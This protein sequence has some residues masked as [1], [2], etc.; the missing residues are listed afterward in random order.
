MESCLNAATLAPDLP[1]ASF[2]RI[3]GAAGFSAVEVRLGAVAE[4]ARTMGIDGV[5]DFF[6]AAGVIPAHCGLSAAPIRSEEDYQAALRLLPSECELAQALGIRT[7]TLV[8]PYRSDQGESDPERMVAKVREVARI[9]SDYGL[10]VTLEFLGL[11]PPPDRRTRGPTTL[12]QTLEFIER[13]DRPHVGVLLDSYHWYLS[14]SHM[15]DLERI[16]AGMPLF[17]HINDAPPGPVETLTDPMRVLPG[18]G[19]IDLVGW[20]R[21][22]K[23]ATGY[24]GPVSLELFN[25]EIRRLDPQIAAERCFRAVSR[26]LAAVDGTG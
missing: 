10:S 9:A 11:H 16:P 21:A 14:G 13:V 7:A 25:E 1:F 2:V 26:L 19:V 17:V 6:T 4:M 22:V 23:R 12:G 3:A 8:L 18:D 5:K 24:D 15:D 20:L